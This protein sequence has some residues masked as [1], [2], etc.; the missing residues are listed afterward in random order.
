[1]SD[2]ELKACK[3]Y[4]D[5]NLSKG[6][7]TASSALYTLLV[8]FVRKP[9]RG[10]WFCVDYQKLNVLTKKDKYLL[11]LIDKTLAQL[12]GC[13]IMSKIDIQH[14]FNCI[15]LATDKDKDLSSFQT[16]FSLYKY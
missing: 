8:L 7:I 4:I 9:S 5:S 11:P 13:T 3:D 2:K 14:T 10:L 1:M 16:W 12:T 15:W 6:F